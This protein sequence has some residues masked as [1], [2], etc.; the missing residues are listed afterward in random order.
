MDI[1]NVGW[2]KTGKQ[3]KGA[4]RTARPVLDEDVVCFLYCLKRV[5][6]LRLS[7]SS[8]PED[9]VWTLMTGEREEW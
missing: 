2:G 4:E 5:R 3:G 1:G 6:C 7:S 8:D 9:V